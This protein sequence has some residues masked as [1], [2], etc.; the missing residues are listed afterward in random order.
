MIRLKDLLEIDLQE[1][2]KKKKK[3]KKKRDACYYKV[4]RRYKV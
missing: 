3:K 1:K 2:R 4:K